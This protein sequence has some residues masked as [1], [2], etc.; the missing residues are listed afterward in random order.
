MTQS[1]R[2]KNIKN[3]RTT[4]PRTKLPRFGAEIQQ[5]GSPEVSNSHSDRSHHVLA[6]KKSNYIFPLLTFWP[7]F[8]SS[9]LLVYLLMSEESSFICFQ[10]GLARNAGCREVA[11][12]EQGISLMNKAAG[13]P[14]G[15]S[16]GWEA[17]V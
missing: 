1:I 8:H 12:Q 13:L 3:S 10:C 14:W 2:G 17:M 15:R 9:S 5:P 16:G 4:T 6:Q 7:Q 11:R